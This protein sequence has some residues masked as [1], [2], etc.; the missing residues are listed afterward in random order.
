MAI[1]SISSMM[2]KPVV[3][4]FFLGFYVAISGNFVSGYPVNGVSEPTN[5]SAIRA[6]ANLVTRFHR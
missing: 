1:V 2:V 5:G 3:V 6:F 4:C